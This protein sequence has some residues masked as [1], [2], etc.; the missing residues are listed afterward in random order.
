MAEQRQ[1]LEGQSRQSMTSYAPQA[2]QQDGQAAQQDGQAA[3]QDGTMTSSATSSNTTSIPQEAMDNAEALVWRA[4]TTGQCRRAEDI[5]IEYN[6]LYIGT[7]PQ[8]I[9]FALCMA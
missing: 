7:D 2:A 3:Q 9:P 1:E 8:E 5:S 4:Q 6:P